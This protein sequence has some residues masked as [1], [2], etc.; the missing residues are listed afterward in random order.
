M[1]SIIFGGGGGGGGPQI[2]YLGKHFW[3]REEKMKHIYKNMIFSCNK[4][5]L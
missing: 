4:N 3:K 5:I 2:I 1:P